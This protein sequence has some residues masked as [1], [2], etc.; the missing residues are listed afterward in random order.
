VSETTTPSEGPWSTPTGVENLANG[1]KAARSALL[2]AAP[3]P[4]TSGFAL[5]RALTKLTIDFVQSVAGLQAWP[6]GWSLVAVGGTGRSELCPGSD[7]DLLL[8]HPKRVSDAELASFGGSLWYP[9]W[10]VGLSV[11]P[12]VH[13]VE[14]AVELAEREVLSAAAWLDAGHL[15]GD[16]STTLRF[17]SQATSSRVKHARRQVAELISLT[18][19]RHQ[20]TG[21]VA[22]LLGPDLRDGHGGLRDLLVMRWIV[23][24]GLPEL[25]FLQERDPETLHA[26]RDTLLSAR[27]ELHRLT[28][29]PHDV[30]ALQEQDAVAVALGLENADVLLGGVSAAARTIAWCTDETLRRVEGFLDRKRA[31]RFGTALKLSADIGL[32]SGEIVLSAGVDPATDS[33]LLLRVAATAALNQLP[34]SRETLRLLAERAP[35]LRD[36]WPD[37]ARNA[38]VALLGAGTATIGV[39]EA[40]DH[41]ELMSRI[42]PEWDTVRA[43]PQRNAYHRFTVD[44][45]LVEAAVNASELVRSVARPDLLLIGT[46]LHDIGKGYPGDHT[47]V[48][49]VLIQDIA[50]RMGFNGHEIE[51]LMAA[52]QFHL[53]LPETATRRDLSDPAVITNVAKLVGD[54]DTLQLLRALT[55]A[56][57]LATGPTAWSP[58][59]GQ[60][61]DDLVQRVEQVLA[62]HRPPEASFPDGPDSAAALAEVRAGEELSIQVTPDTA[63]PELTILTV[64]A[65]DR[66]GLFSSLTGALA[67]TGVDVLG[68]DVWTTDDGIALDVLR[69]T[70]RLGGDTDWRR[71][72]RLIRGAL[73]G[74]VD[75]KVELEKRAKS[76]ARKEITYAAPEVLVDDD[77]EERA[78]V[79]EVRSPDMLALL[80]RVSTTLTNLGLDIRA[81]KVTTLGHE[82]VDSFSVVRILPDGTRSKQPGNG[83]SNAEVRTA[84]LTELS[85]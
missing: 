81:A 4:S 3:A 11:T 23:A 64:A 55:E 68:A 75:L 7:V 59:K 14:S 80:H 28:K 34:I 84:L 6:A 51:T 78:T 57:S 18:R 79:V 69:V 73:D 85:P 76:Y 27:A 30:L 62:G 82:V 19:L 2:D 74:S 32:Q 58:W 44:R 53:L 12:G 26:E 37:R 21:D 15:A 65:V 49:V 40:L 9:L 77:I 45:H 17:V 29:R 35:V 83:P 42:L 60:L 31:S 38:L 70:R 16:E 24:T 56:D 5:I 72:E 47:E 10:D 1:Y 36:L 41:Y 63:A 8:L 50:A 61:C 46:W 54:I 43:K 71:V 39:F 13:T 66:P 25:S 48:G 67:V 52:V 22:F 20:K 33:S